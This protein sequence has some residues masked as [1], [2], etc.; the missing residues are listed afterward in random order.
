[1]RAE[2]C[3]RL[4]IS[5]KVFKQVV[6]SNDIA[7]SADQ[8]GMVQDCVEK[9]SSNVADVSNEINTQQHNQ[10]AKMQRVVEKITDQRVENTV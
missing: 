9:L 5:T 4:D 7:S 8:L 2:F 10:E 3:E 6:I 1:M